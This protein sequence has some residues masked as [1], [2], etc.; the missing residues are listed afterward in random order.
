MATVRLTP[1]HRRQRLAVGRPRGMEQRTVDLR[2]DPARHTPIRLHHIQLPKRGEGD[3]AAVRRQRDVAD[4]ARAEGGRVLDRVVEVEAGACVDDHVGGEGDLGGLAAARLAGGQRHAPQPTAVRRDQRG[5]VGREGV[6]R[7]QV[8]GR[9]ALHVVALDGVDEPAFVA[10][11]EVAC[12]QACGV[13]VAGAVDEGGAV[14]GHGRAESRAV[15]AG[16]RRAPTRLAVIADELVL[17]EGCVVGPVARPLRQVDVAAR[18]VEGGTDGL[19]LFG[20]ADQRD[21]AAAVAVEEPRLR[22][23]AERAEGA[24][25]DQV[26]AVGRPFGRGV[27]VVVAARDL[28]RVGAVGAQHP[29]ILAATAVGDEDDFTAVGTVARLALEGGAGQERGRG[30]ACD[31]EGVEVAEQVEDEGGAVGADVDR[32]PRA[33]AGGEADLAGGLEGEGGGG[34]GVGGV[35]GFLRVGRGGGRQGQECGQ[36]DQ[37]EPPSLLVYTVRSGPGQCR[38]EEVA[39][40]TSH[41]KILAPAVMPGV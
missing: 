41:F 3:P 12:A 18:G 23:A 35:G 29:Q 1:A 33:F 32:D 24:R 2:A 15:A 38:A 10:G 19:E 14:G 34:E 7:Q 6:A 8:E 5:A 28:G 36:G 37:R 11:G 39:L 21:P 4:L 31:G 20:L 30:A 17:R 26:L 25:C 9:T 16:D 27:K 22:G 40:P 13:L